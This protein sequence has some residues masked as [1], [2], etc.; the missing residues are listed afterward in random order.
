MNM[1]EL[2][3]AV[4]AL[5]HGY[6]V[7]ARTMYDDDMIGHAETLSNHHDELIEVLAKAAVF[8]AMKKALIKEVGP[9][10]AEQFNA[11]VD[12]FRTEIMASSPEA[13]ALKI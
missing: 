12:K 3:K 2:Y 5:K 10:I 11:K 9:E 7:N 1:S 8:D 6:E 13:E 4:T